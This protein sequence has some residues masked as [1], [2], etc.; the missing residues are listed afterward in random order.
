MGRRE[1]PRWWDRHAGRMVAARSAAALPR[2]RPPAAARP[3]LGHA[4]QR[5][6]QRRQHRHLA[7]QR[8]DAVGTRL[9]ADAADLR[10]DGGDAHAMA[11]GDVAGLQA[12]AQ[13]FE[14]PRLGQRQAVVAREPLHA[15]AAAHLALAHRQL[16]RHRA[17]GTAV[18]QRHHR[19]RHAVVVLAQHQQ[20]A[21]AALRGG[22]QR[23]VQPH[24]VGRRRVRAAAAPAAAAGAGRRARSAPHG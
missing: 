1:R 18:A 14:H 7:H 9:R 17:A 21:Q 5:A 6:H 15:Q 13:R 20:P 8:A 3:G 12:F 23:V 10:A 11:R 4:A 19:H 2:I 24:D 16:R 22:L